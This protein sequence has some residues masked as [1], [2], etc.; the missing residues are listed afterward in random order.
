MAEK[1][2]NGIKYRL[3][4]LPASTAIPLL[5][6][7]IA[8]AGP[9]AEHLPVIVAANS[10]EDE[11]GRLF[12]DAAFLQAISGIMLQMGPE[13]FMDL[14]KR[15]V[16]LAEKQRPSDEAIGAYSPLDFDG[17]FTGHL[18]DILPVA[19]WVLGS[20]YGDFFTGSAGI[21]L[22]GMFKAGFLPKE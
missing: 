4:E 14:L 7:I 10:D 6:E 2:I 16:Q 5:A 3:G 1:T 21:G 19:R 12:G 9:L 13:G 18:D 17:D 22:L 15:I 20:T 8:A 11:R